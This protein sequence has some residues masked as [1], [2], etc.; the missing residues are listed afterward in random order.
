MRAIEKDLMSDQ[1]PLLIK[2]PNGRN[3]S[4]TKR[5]CYV[6]N[7]QMNNAEWMKCYQFLGSYLASAMV[8]SD[9][10]HVLLPMA[11]TFWMTLQDDQ[12]Q[13]PWL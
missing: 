13:K 8:T 9:Q 1:L 3:H 4:G 6:L 5:D 11:P 12:S 2:T 10:K 7:P